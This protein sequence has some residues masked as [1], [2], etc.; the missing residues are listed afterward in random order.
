[1][2]VLVRRAMLT[3][4]L[5]GIALLSSGPVAGALTSDG[6]VVAEA[7]RQVTTDP[8]PARDY[9]GPALAVDP[10][11]PSTIVMAV[12]DARGGGCGIRLSRDGGLS[13][14]TT[15]Q[16]IMPADLPYCVQRNF[17]PMMAPVIAS[18]GTLYVGVSGSSVKDT[19]NGPITALLI[20]STDMGRTSEAITVA[21]PEGFTY[22]PANGQTRTGFNQWRIPTLAVDPGNPKKLYM[23]W[24][25]WNGGI[26]DISFAAFP[27]RSYIATS[28]DGG[29]T[30]TPPVDVLRTTIDDAKAKDLGIVFTGDRVTQSDTPQMV[31]AKD[32][33][34]YGFTK[35]QPPS[36]PTGQP[37]ATARL[38]M[39]KSTDG[40]KTWATSVMNKGAQRID[41]PTAAIDQ[42]T[43]DLYVTYASRGAANA[44]GTPANPSE[45]Y[46]TASSD[47]GRTW[48]DSLNIT[49]DDPARKASQYFPNVSV[50]PDGRVDVAWY[51]FRNDAFFNPGAEGNMGSAVGQRYWDA[52][53]AY[54]SDGGRTWSTNLRITN[55]SVDSKGGVTFNNEDVRA[56]IGLASSASAA[57]VAWPDTRASVNADV[58]DAYF[59]RV[60]FTAPVA[61]G[62]STS[63]GSKLPWVLL[64]ATIALAVGGI[65]LIVASRWSASAASGSGAT[66]PTTATTKPAEV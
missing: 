11:D 15:A 35:E 46:V 40:G 26:D 36:P 57:Y 28:D 18:D 39:F 6:S 48:S 55:P 27:Q 50:A 8:N 56:P 30:W 9:V 52:Y 63:G 42:R 24:R 14:T 54:S 4:T 2:F 45:V 29:T 47:G 61:L 31:V 62:D 38:F 23:G 51:D 25:L 37:A 34:V 44:T 12:A 43:G 3:G 16:T 32:G 22:T 5:V 58:E 41:L 59:S 19:P 17:G 33:T 13:W 60:R 20:R 53:S 21:R 64:G 7:P 66:E 65:V 1:M 49:D 10:N